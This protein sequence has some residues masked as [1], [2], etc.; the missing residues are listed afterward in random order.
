MSNTLYMSAE[1]ERQKNIKATVYTL[2]VTG[3][4][5]LLLI[6]IK[7]TIPLDVNKPPT[8][9]IIEISL[10]SGDIGS[11][12][13]Q[14]QLPG[15]PA[16][17]KQVAYTP[18]QPVKSSAQDDSK[19]VDNNDKEK[20]A[21]PLIKPTVIKPK[22]TRI[23]TE[24]KTVKTIAK[25]Q[26]MVVQA[27]PRPKAILGHTI[28]GN[29]NGGNGA[30]SYKPGTNEGIAGGNGDQ[31]R[32]GG[33]PNGKSYT[34]TPRNFGVKEFSIPN[35]SFEDD[36]NQNA[37]VAMEIET[38]GAGKVITANYTSRGSTGTASERMIE[39]ARR[40]A[41]QLKVGSGQKGTVIFNFKVRG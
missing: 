1:F 21:P 22:A 37:K 16:Q 15:A 36:F 3:A 14:P 33:N 32:P 6:L 13:D 4:I 10:G 19:D 25:P 7:L 38:D 39:I 23:N 28:G 2:V 5:I 18:P 40:R 20:S 35:Q 11:G 27:P 24:N 41:Y 8:Q 30:D 17:A 9:E 26:P 29:G 12:H 31:G 34:G